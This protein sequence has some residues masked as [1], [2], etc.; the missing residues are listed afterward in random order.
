M[1]LALS[2]EGEREYAGVERKAYAQERKGSSTSS[3]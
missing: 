3:R 2:G 1:Y